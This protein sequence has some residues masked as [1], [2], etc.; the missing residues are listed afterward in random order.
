MERFLL[1]K[2]SR[3]SGG[4]PAGTTCAS[5]VGVPSYLELEAA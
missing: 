3:H 4:K 2:M 5:R 1:E